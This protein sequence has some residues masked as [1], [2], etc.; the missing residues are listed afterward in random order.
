MQWLRTSR[1]DLLDADAQFCVLFHGPQTASLADSVLKAYPL[2]IKPGD[3]S[4]GKF[5]DGFPNLMIKDVETIRGRDVVFLASFLNQNDML[6]QLSVLYSLPRYLARSLLV[7]LP[8]FPTGTME[9]VDEEGQIATAMTF[10]RLLSAVPITQSGPSKLLIYD[11]HALQNRFYFSDT[12]LPMLV[13]AVPLFIQR[14]K[15]DHKNEKVLLPSLM[16]EQPRDLENCLQIGLVLL[17]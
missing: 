2:Y 9:R 11:I 14:V 7:V 16:M 3:I 8:Y 17:V 4:W 5:E 10:A 12:V 15:E 13:S 6:S 1:S